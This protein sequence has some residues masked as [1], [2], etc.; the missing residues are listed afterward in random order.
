[1]ARNSLVVDYVI[2]EDPQT[3]PAAHLLPEGM[4]RLDKF[5]PTQVWR[6]RREISSETIESSPDV[7]IKG[8]LDRLKVSHK[9]FFDYLGAVQH[10]W[11]VLHPQM[12]DPQED[13]VDA[14]TDDTDV[15]VDWN[16][17]L[18]RKSNPTQL[19]DLIQISAQ[20]V[21]RCYGLTEAIR[22][23]QDIMTD[24]PVATDLTKLRKSVGALEAVKHTLLVDL[25]TSDARPRVYGS[26]AF[27]TYSEI[28][29]VWNMEEIEI[30]SK[31]SLDACESLLA[32][33]R[34][35]SQS[36]RDR[37]RA[38]TLLFLTIVSSVSAVFSFIGYVNDSGN[39]SDFVKIGVPA[40]IALGAATI[41]GVLRRIS[42]D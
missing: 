30:S 18:V 8:E 32:N 15:V 14:Y 34:Q 11:P 3:F 5:G 23:C 26:F 12:S 19:E 28:R 38:D 37:W 40:I 21:A 35:A 9:D 29:R 10:W 20:M 13:R 27:E 33:I 7:V 31:R 36:K 17:L 39:A 4:T 41:F 6:W 2:A 16:Y 24:I 42:S 1:M 22:N 25:V